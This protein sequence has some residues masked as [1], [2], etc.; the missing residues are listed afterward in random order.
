MLSAVDPK[1]PNGLAE[2]LERAGVSGSELARLLGT[3]RQNVSRWASG[4]RELTSA[5]AEQIA[6]LLPPC[7]S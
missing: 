7:Y 3:N 2:A 1:Y 5:I 6:P 4:E